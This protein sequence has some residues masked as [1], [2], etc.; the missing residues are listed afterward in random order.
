MKAHDVWL[1]SDEIH[2]DIMRKGMQHLP[3][4]T[5]LSDYDKVITAMSAKQSV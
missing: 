1:I 2:C 4:A 3:F 5:V